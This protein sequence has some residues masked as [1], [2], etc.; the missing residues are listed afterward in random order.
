MF[1]SVRRY[2]LQPARLLCPCNSPGKNTGVGSHFL[3]QGIFM[4]QGLNRSLLHSR[5]SLYHL[6]HQG[7]PFS[8]MLECFSSTS[9]PN[10]VSSYFIYFCLFIFSLSAC[11]S[12]LCSWFAVVILSIFSL[13]RS[14]SLGHLCFLPVPRNP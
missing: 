12:I 8:V 6:S 10:S 3:L 7:S 11:I 1:D 9:F 4:I 5:Q 14:I 13:L 2:R